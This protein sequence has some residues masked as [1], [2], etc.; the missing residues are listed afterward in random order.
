MIVGAVLCPAAPLLIPGVADGVV[1][2]QSGWV[3]EVRSTVGRLAGRCDRI[4][5]VTAGRQRRW[6]DRL[7]RDPG[8][9]PF[10]RGTGW[11]ISETT[12]TP[13]PTWAP[14]IW[15]ARALLPEGYLIGCEL[16]LQSGLRPGGGIAAAGP[17]A[18]DPSVALGLLALA[19]GA[20][21]HGP[22]APLAA[23]GRAEQFE[24][25]LE[26][27]LSTGDPATLRSWAADN[28]ELAVEL[29]A[30]T[31]GALALFAELTAGS[32]WSATAEYLG[33]PY[34]VGYHLASWWR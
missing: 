3:P 13:T 15:V 33:A 7:P 18:T 22:G 28:R 30:T 24:H 10:G 19:D 34:G 5:V 14:G 31:A 29:G 8:I 11:R 23:D 27:A 32:T 26:R 17:I 12:P 16:D 21:C 2:E 9:H 4:L 20:L 1:A 6:S 25:I